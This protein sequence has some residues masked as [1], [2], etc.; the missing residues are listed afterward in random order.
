MLSWRELYGTSID[1]TSI[2]ASHHRI[3]A[4]SIITENQLGISNHEKIDVSGRVTN[5]SRVKTSAVQ[6]SYDSTF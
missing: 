3:I 6:Y 4:S 2:M 1:I 5:V